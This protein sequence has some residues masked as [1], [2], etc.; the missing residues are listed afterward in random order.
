MQAHPA[1]GEGEVKM[2][3]TQQIFAQDGE[4]A[5]HSESQRATGTQ[6]GEAGNI[7]SSPKLVVATKKVA[8]QRLRFSILHRILTL[9]IIK[10]GL[11]KDWVYFRRLR[12]L[13]AAGS[14][15]EPTQRLPSPHSE[16]L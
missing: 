15:E 2:L 3:S 16:H 14:K 11:Q 4:L 1:K 12:I 5:A 9:L 6:H 8:Q 10:G 7:S 13:T